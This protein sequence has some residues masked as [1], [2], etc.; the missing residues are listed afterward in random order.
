MTFIKLH[1]SS[2]IGDDK[3]SEGPAVSAATR[4]KS[5]AEHNITK[6]MKIFY[7][8]SADVYVKTK[9]DLWV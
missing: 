6:E 5:P 7:Y 1:S 4:I 3:L 2:Y 8:F 9:F